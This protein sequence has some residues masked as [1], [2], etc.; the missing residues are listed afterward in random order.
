MLAATVLGQADQVQAEKLYASSGGPAVVK[1]PELELPDR[2]IEAVVAGRRAAPPAAAPPRRDAYLADTAKFAPLVR[3]AASKYGLDPWLLHA[4][5]RAESGYDPYAVSPQG[6]IGLMQLLPGTAER[7]GVEDPFDP[8]QNVYAGARYLRDLL[9]M[10]GN[11]LE[12]ALAAYNAG[13]GAVLRA[14]RQVPKMR[15]T[16]AYI[17][18][19]LGHY[20]AAREADSFP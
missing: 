1:L 14:G 11:N 3:G 13:E 8:R 9:A 7:F 17:P 10:F 16:L 5:I 18:R 6:A 12:L 20:R 15:E 4:V 19:V 2:R